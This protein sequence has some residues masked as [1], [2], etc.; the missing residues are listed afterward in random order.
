MQAMQCVHCNAYSQGSGTPC[1]QNNILLV[2]STVELPAWCLY[3]LYHVNI[4]TKN[5]I[6][7]RTSLLHEKNCK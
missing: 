3:S 6:L 4:K 1:W 7:L 5:I 2:Y